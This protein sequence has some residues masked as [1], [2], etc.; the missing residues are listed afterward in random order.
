MA[1]T[2]DPSVLI[3]GRSFVKR[4][5][6]DLRAGFDC[7]ASIDF[8]LQGTASVRLHGVGGRTVDKLKSFDLHVV[9]DLSPDIVI[10]EIGTNDLPSSKPEV[11]KVGHPFTGNSG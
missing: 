5:N 4:L 3:L 7:R 10:L 9:Q 11:V 2:R 8:Q 1:L 6:R